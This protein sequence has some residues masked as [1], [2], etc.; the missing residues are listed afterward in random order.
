MNSLRLEKHYLAWAADV[1]SD[2]NP[3]AAGLGALV[4]PDKP[5]LLAGPALRKIRDSGPTERLCWFSA[6]LPAGPTA[7]TD[8]L[9]S[10][11]ELV[12]HPD[13]DFTASVR[14]AGFGYTIGRS[15]FSA[16]LPAAVADATAQTA[17]QRPAFEIEVAATRYPATRHAVPRYDPPGSRIRAWSATRPPRQVP[18]KRTTAPPLGARSLAGKP[19]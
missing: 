11:G 17:D 1:R 19:S 8:V 5:G 2:D 14:S 7:E 4:R 3:Y 6:D 12:T 9:I 15:I 16:Y 18:V 10:D 13:H